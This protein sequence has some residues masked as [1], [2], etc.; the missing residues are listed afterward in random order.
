[1]D[2]Y[3]VFVLVAAVV[4]IAA[5]FAWLILG[6]APQ[7]TSPLTQTTTPPPTAP[8]LKILWVSNPLIDKTWLIERGMYERAWTWSTFIKGQV[9]VLPNGR[10]VAV[11][12]QK[13]E[14]YVFAANGSLVKKFEYA[15]GEV[16]YTAQFSPDGKYFAV[17]LASKEGE[18]V[19]YSTDTWE[20]VFRY[21]VASD[22]L[23]P[24]NATESTILKQPWYGNRI[25]YILFDKKGK[26][27]V[28]ACQQILNPKTQ[29]PVYVN[30]TVDLFKVYPELKSAFPNRTAYRV[31]FWSGIMLSKIIAIDTATW[32]VAWKWPKSGNAY[33]LI[34]MLSTDGEGKYLAFPTWWYF[35]PRNP[36]LW[37]SGTVFVLNTTNGEVL[38]KFE[39]PPLLPVFE[40]ASIYNGVE[41]TDDGRYLV[42]AYE[43]GRVYA[44][45]N[46]ESVKEGRA[47]VLWKSTVQA[48]IASDVLLIPQKG[49]EVSVKKSYIYAWVGL[50]GVV[51]DR[52]VVYTSA[53]Y[54]T[55]WAPGYERKPLI[56]HPNQT[57]LFVLD[58]KNGSLLYVDKFFGKP[59]YGKVRPFAISGC[60]LAAS[61]GNDWITADASMA[62]LYVWDLCRLTEVARFLT[63]PNYG[64]PLDVGIGGGQIYVLTGP[65]NIAH[66]EAEPANIVGEYR[67]VAFGT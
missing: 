61:I 27:Y 26:M 57:K 55:Y 29:S 15:L 41:L 45:D 38:Y 64:V 60:L 67:L 20:P 11:A 35:D 44:I 52:V 65:I 14:V 56:Q 23:G 54:A 2:K 9:I 22:L 17:G 34:P 31:S 42:A 21:K 50:A 47:V 51:K 53:T 49:G 32:N 33:T 13:G 48:P 66:S 62:G 25:M 3:K 59:E 10:L 28:P 6:K 7:T 39:A 8:A 30:V 36:E 19:V 63:V 16:P 43:D 37:H 18:L 4:I 58:L 24:S 46:V 1:M 5:F 40:R 12:T